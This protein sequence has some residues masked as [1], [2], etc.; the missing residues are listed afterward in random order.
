MKSPKTPTVTI[1]RIPVRGSS[2]F[3]LRQA[4]T[5]GFFSVVTSSVI[6]AGQQRTAGQRQGRLL[7]R[8]FAGG[9]GNRRRCARPPPIGRPFDERSTRQFLTG[10]RGAK[11]GSTL[12]RG[13]TPRH[14]G[15]FPAG[16]TRFLESRHGLQAPIE[17]SV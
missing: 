15:L 8:L 9:F 11:N 17:T 10:Y 1:T 7:G 5:R 16:Q 3:G 14:V 4:A 6:R 12:Y 2:S 13:K